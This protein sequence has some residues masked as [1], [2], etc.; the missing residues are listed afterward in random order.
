MKK[1]GCLN[2]VVFSESDHLLT[3]FESNEQRFRFIENIHLSVPID[4][5]RYNPGGSCITTLCLTQVP[6]SRSEH[7]ILTQGARFLQEVRPHL[8]EFHTRAQRPMFK[9][10][11]SNLATVKPSVA[12]LIYKGLTL[13]ASVAEHPETEER[14]R[15]IYLG[16]HGLLADLRNISPGRPSGTY[17][18]LFLCSVWCC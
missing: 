6:E 7:E 16:N 13:D 18:K 4:L 11:L 5:I 15:L 10:S 3:Q 1:S 12:E 17:D 8:K 9:R 2:P 14:L